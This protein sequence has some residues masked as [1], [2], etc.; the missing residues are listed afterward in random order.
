[1]RDDGLTRGLGWASA[2]LG[3]PQPVAPGGFA[4]GLGVGDAARYRL[5]TLVVGVRELAAAAGLLGR[6]HPAWLGGRGSGATRWTS[7]SSGAR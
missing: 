1:L 2:A 7:P 3:V 5:T 6:P 4:R